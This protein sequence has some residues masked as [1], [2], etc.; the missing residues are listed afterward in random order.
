MRENEMF[1]TKNIKEERYNQEKR[2][3]IERADT[4]IGEIRHRTQNQITHTETYRDAQL[5][6]LGSNESTIRR[7]AN[8]IIVSAKSVAEKKIEEVEIRRNIQLDMLHQRYYPKTG[9]TRYH[10]KAGEKP[11]LALDHSKINP[12]HV[13]RAERL[14]D[15]NALHEITDELNR[16]GAKLGWRP[17]EKEN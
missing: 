16:E 8:R 10:L 13:K 9:T 2:A 14:D 6:K 17:P 11:I 12:G 7:E 4:E 5:A 15:P 1:E 3:I